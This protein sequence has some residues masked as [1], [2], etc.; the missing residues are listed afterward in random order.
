MIINAALTHEEC[1]ALVE[2]FDT[3]LQ[4]RVE[5]DEYYGGSVGLYQPT[6]SLQHVERL[7]EIV[8]KQ[9]GKLKFENS[10][11]RE[12]TT[13]S[14]LKIHTDRPDLDV[15]LS[16]CLKHDFA[17]EYPLYVSNKA[18]DG[19]WKPL[20]NYDAWLEDAAVFELGV[21]EGVAVEGVKYPHW[22]DK[23]SHSGRAIYIFY[24]W[25]VL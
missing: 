4:T 3:S 20:L 25:R 9:Y 12:Y 17:G 2:F 15:S 11:M 5:Q 23:F 18:W 16:I 22:R 7:Q 6:V 14:M 1:D 19:L 24:H 8:E 10:F 13:G 21:G